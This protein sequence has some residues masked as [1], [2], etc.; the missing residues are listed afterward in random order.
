ME[1]SQKLVGTN[2]PTNYKRGKT[3]GKVVKT[4]GEYLQKEGSIAM[5]MRPD[6]PK[7]LSLHGRIVCR[8]LSTVNN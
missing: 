6:W 8:Y 2:Q 3:S 4:I 7:R 1:I 5:L